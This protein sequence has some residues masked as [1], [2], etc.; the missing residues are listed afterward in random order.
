LGR[1]AGVLGSH[2]K[3]SPPVTCAVID[4]FYRMG[5]SD[6]TAP[7][8]ARLTTSPFARRTPRSANIMRWLLSED[9]F[10]EGIFKTW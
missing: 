4:K 2:A 3:K 8:Y 9:G 5:W 6:R 10:E 1:T 7:R